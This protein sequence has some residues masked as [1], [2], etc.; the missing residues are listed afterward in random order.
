[1][2]FFGFLVAKFV[3]LLNFKKKIKNTLLGS[4]IVAKKC[5]GILNFF[6]FHIL[7]IAKFG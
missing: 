5:E 7:F 3:Q 4:S 2:F 6:Y 1:V